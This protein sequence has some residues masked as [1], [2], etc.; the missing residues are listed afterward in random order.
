MIKKVIE[1]ITQNF[2]VKCEFC[3]KSIK[4]KH[5]HFRNV[6][7][8]EF[9][10]PKNTSFCDETCCSKYEKYE[11]NSFKKAYLCS[12]CPVPPGLLANRN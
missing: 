7:R 9:V 10:Y 11:V 3:K 5:A 4:R 1:K 8:L 2:S 6:K 12:S